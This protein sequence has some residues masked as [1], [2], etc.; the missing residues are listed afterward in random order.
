MPVLVV[1]GSEIKLTFLA[2]I[3]KDF[4]YLGVEKVQI[5]TDSK[6]A[7]RFVTY[8]ISKWEANGWRNIRGHP[9]RNQDLIQQLYEYTHL[10]TIKWVYLIYCVLTFPHLNFIKEPSSNFLGFRI[11]FPLVVE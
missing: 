6:N 4:F 5:N 9:V 11:T 3:C 8:F 2:I 7:V 1:C 10:V